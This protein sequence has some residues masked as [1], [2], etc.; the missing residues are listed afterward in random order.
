[1]TSGGSSRPPAAPA[2]TGAPAPAPAGPAPLGR[3]LLAPAALRSL[4]VLAVLLAWVLLPLDHATLTPAIGLAFLGLA[5]AEVAEVRRVH[6]AGRRAA[7]VRALAPLA[8]AVVLLAAPGDAGTPARAAGAVL[9]VRAAGDLLALATVGDRTGARAWLAGLAAAE[10]AGAVAGLLLTD[11]FGQAALVTLAFA[12]LAGGLVVTLRALEPRDPTADP[13]AGPVTTPV[14]DPDDQ[15]GRPWVTAPIPRGGAM[16]PDERA[17]LADRVHFDGP[18]ARQRLA[19]FVLL[20]V[21]ATV[22]ATYGV[23]AGSVAAVIGGMIVAPLMGP[24]QALAVGL[25]AG[26]GRRA[27]RAALVLTGGTLAVLAVSMLIAA[28]TRDLVVLLDGEQVLA[29]T[30]PAL[31]DLAVALAAGVAGGLALV[32]ADVGDS[33]PGVAIAV[34]LVPPLCVSGS[35]LAGG[36]PSEALGAFLLFAINMVAIVVATGA[37]LVLHGFG[38]VAGLGG[39]RLLTLSLAGGLALAVLAIPLATTGLDAVRSEDEEAAVRSALDA[40]LAPVPDAQVLQVVTDDGGVGVLLVSAVRPPPT[41]DLD[42]RVEEILGRPVDVSV[43]WLE[44]RTSP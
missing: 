42:A 36:R 38:T 29:R 22:I 23:L 41:S 7:A 30:A 10:T 34:S 26:A 25:V 4:L 19:R 37:V 17:A 31:P 28:T 5:T 39:H 44:P 33:L 6:P 18:Q 40:W 12:W 35:C 9:A 21:L 27:A 3:G 14:A 2:A 43:Q 13:T 11:L 20:L 24:I 1:M 16:T 15:D 32:R 8:G